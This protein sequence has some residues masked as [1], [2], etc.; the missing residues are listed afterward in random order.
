MPKLLLE[1]EKN[2]HEY[3][4][5][6]ATYEEAKQKFKKDQESIGKKPAEAIILKKPEIEI[7]ESA[8]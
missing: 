3:Q 4:K 2:L 8:Y 6:C 5:S 1:K 7:T